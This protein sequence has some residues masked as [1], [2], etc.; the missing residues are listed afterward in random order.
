MPGANVE[1]GRRP[2]RRIGATV[3]AGV[4][5]G[6]AFVP[7]TAGCRGADAAFTWVDAYPNPKKNT[8]TTAITLVSLRLQEGTLPDRGRSGSV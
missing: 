2:S 7:T 8:F 4:D 1:V 5:A 3:G 6:A